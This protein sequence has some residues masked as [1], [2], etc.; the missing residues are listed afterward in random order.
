M[1]YIR[2]LA[3][4]SLLIWSTQLH[5]E[6]VRGSRNEP[7]LARQP[8]EMVVECMQNKSDGRILVSDPH[9]PQIDVRFRVLQYRPLRSDDGWSSG[10]CRILVT[11]GMSG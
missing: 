3:I 8:V 7:P 6:T 11:R 4:F 9:F 1:L 2:K 10:Q 5:A